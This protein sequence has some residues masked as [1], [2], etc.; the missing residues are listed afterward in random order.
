[1]LAFGLMDMNIGLRGIV[2]PG[3]YI[4]NIV[5]SHFYVRGRIR[6]ATHSVVSN[7]FS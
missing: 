4:F 6:R 2:V 7:S 3:W 1:M 5:H